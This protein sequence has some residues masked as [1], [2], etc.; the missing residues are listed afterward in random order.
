MKDQEELL[1]RIGEMDGE[2]QELLVE[3]SRLKE[4][5]VSDMVYVIMWVVDDIWWKIDGGFGSASWTAR[6]VETSAVLLVVVD[7]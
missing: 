6:R 3:V 5:I 2:N 7:N 4:V 1:K